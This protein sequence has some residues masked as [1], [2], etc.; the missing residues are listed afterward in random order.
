MQ[1]GAT[2][3]GAV[4]DAHGEEA[5]QLWGDRTWIEA[6]PSSSNMQEEP[7]AEFSVLSYNILA[8]CYAKPDV[9]GWCRP[10]TLKWYRRR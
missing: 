3:P 1:G 8:Q 2:L 7:G 9:Y 10:V 6:H 4:S 5:E